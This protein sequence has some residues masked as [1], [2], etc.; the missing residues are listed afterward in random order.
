VD[1]ATHPEWQ[2]RGIFSRLTLALVDQMTKEGVAFVFNTPNQKSGPG[3][4]KMGWSV[5]GRMAM[6]FR[7]LRA[8]RLITAWLGRQR[9]DECEQM[10]RAMAEKVASPELLLRE[11]EAAEL[12]ARWAGTDHRLATALTPAYLRWRYAEVPGFEYKAAW[13][14]RGGEGAA[15]VFRIKRHGS[16]RELRF[17][18]IL[19]APTRDSVRLGSK[20]VRDVVRQVDADI[21]S[22]IAAPGT[23]EQRVLLRAGFLPVP[24]A[25]PLLTARPLGLQAMEVDPLQS[26]NWRLSIGTLEL[27]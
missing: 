4:L 6:W 7:P 14:F 18:E 26:A 27:F 20:L 17:C 2:G 12:L 23:P 25:A 3:Y 22:A 10:D 15:V 5:V 1:T 19:A 16:I 13:S 24:R 8:R 9:T 11:S 21:S